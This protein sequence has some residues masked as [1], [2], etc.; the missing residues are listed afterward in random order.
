MK[1]TVEDFEGSGNG[2]KWGTTPTFVKG[3]NQNHH[4]PQSR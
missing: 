3:S 1:K 4:N 2:L